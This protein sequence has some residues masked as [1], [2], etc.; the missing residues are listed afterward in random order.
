MGIGRNLILIA[1]NCLI[2]LSASAEQ[3]GEEYQ[4][5]PRIT[6]VATSQYTSGKCATRSPVSARDCAANWCS[7]QGR[8]WEECRQNM[9]CTEDRGP[10]VYR[11]ITVGVNTQGYTQSFSADGDTRAQAYDLLIRLCSRYG[12]PVMCR[13]N[14]SC[15]N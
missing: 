15:L 7:D 10:L 4:D 5:G 1:V 9:T 2:G 13:R 12:S 11:C 6:C 3:L 14:A 8:H